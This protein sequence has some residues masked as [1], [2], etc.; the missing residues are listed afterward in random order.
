MKKI[1]V[2]T[3]LLILFLGKVMIAQNRE[4][5]IAAG[6]LIV[7]ITG[8][9]NNKGDVKIGLFNSENSFSA[10][11]EKYRGAVIEIKEKKAVW[12]CH[13]IRLHLL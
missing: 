1:V 11:G 7:V 6:D 2:L 12:I 3:F 8:L 13:N 4:D 10:K 9:K 5:K